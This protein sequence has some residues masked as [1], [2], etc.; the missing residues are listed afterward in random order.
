MS[1]MSATMS[2]FT[3]GSMSSRTSSQSAG[4]KC[5][6]R[7]ATRLEPQPTWRTRFIPNAGVLLGRLRV[8]GRAELLALLAR[9]LRAEHVGVVGPAVD[10]HDLL[11]DE[12]EHQ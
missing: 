3:S 1:V 5:G 12:E 2:G 8:E 11:V 6:W 10:H 7:S 4:W 9:V